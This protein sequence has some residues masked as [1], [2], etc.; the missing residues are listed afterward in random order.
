MLTLVL[1]LNVYTGFINVDL[2]MCLYRELLSSY[3]VHS[4]FAVHGPSSPKDTVS[5]DE[6]LKDSQLLI[7]RMTRL[8]SMGRVGV[9]YDHF[10]GVSAG[11][12]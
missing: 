6:N 3:M 9:T 5:H 12:R 7:F 4:G 8:K 10:K 1:Y 2:L 11:S